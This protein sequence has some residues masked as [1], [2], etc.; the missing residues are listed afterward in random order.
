M[1]RDGKTSMAVNLATTFVAT[2]KKVLLIDANFRQPNL[3]SLFPKVAAEDSAARF[4]FG[5]SSVLMNQ[6]SPAEAVRPSG[7][8]GLDIID[9]GPL[10]ANPS[11]LLSS[12]RMEDLLAKQRTNYDYI[13]VDGPPVLLVSDAK[14]LAGLV[15]ATLLVF[16]AAATSRGAAQRTIRELTQ[17]NARIIGCV[18]FAARAIKGGYFHEQLKSYRKYQKKAR[19]A[20]SIA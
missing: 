9:C 20:G 16:N 2:D 3:H 17:V 13:I 6:C 19:L 14:V 7:I 12:S 10:P 8:E 4:D 11:E 1:A 15:D 18:L 5:L